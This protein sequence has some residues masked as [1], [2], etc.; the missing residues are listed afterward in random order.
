MS[1]SACVVFYGIRFEVSPDETEA[2][3]LRSDARL[4]AAKRGGLKVYWANFGG[5]G[6]RYL[7]FIG[8]PM[9]ILGPENELEVR[10]T[11]EQVKEL[12]D[13]TREKL[14]EAGLPGEPALYMQWEEDV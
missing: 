6:E 3:E 10:L 8:M 12:L 5:L 13:S 2:L 1:A 7:L 9:G 11:P 14:L 4:L